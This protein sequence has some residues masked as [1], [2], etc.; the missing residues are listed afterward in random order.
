MVVIIPGHPPVH[1]MGLVQPSLTQRLSAALAWLRNLF[2]PALV[3]CPHCPGTMQPV[4]AADF[5]ICDRCG[6][7]D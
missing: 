7:T 1:G 4:G 5:S 2:S 6:H 3:K